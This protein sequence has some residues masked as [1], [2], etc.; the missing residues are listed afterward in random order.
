MGALVNV[1]TSHRMYRSDNSN[2]DRQT[3]LKGVI[4]K[5][6]DSSK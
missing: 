2:H 3:W 5:L 6:I 1:C 4:S